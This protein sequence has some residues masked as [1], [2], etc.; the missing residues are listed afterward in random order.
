MTTRNIIDYAAA[1]DAVEMRNALY[2]S[3]H[4]RVS[5]HL[6][7][8]KQEVAKSLISQEEEQPEQED[9]EEVQSQEQE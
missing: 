7:S 3:I 4:D 5:A 8:Y 6:D 1:D 9:T 2:A